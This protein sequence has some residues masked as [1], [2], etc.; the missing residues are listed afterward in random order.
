MSRAFA[1]IS[2]TPNV[3]AMQEQYGSATA[4]AGFL[5]DDVQRGDR[6]GPDE[7]AFIAG[8]DGFFQATVS[9]ANW[10]YVQFRGGPVG[11]VKVLDDST[12]AYADFRGNRQYLSAGNLTGNDRIALVL[13]DYPSRRRLKVWGRAK[14]VDAKDDPGLIEQIHDPSYRAKPERA[15]VITLAA[16][17]WNCPQ[18][19]PQRFTVEEL[20][21]R[22]APL[23]EEMADLKAQNQALRTALDQANE[24]DRSP[25]AA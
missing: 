5:G 7:I 13:V 19:I 21:Q 17:D 6:L 2:F 23:R 25:G 10:P 4:Y 22:L 12:I 16:I 20:E 15:V 3:R 1:E 8:I 9:E 11:F 24:H 18:H 14:L